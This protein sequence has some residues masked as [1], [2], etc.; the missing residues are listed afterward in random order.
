VISHRVRMKGFDIGRLQPANEVQAG[1][2]K[3]YFLREPEEGKEMVELPVFRL[4]EKVYDRDQTS[5]IGK[6]VVDKL[7]T[8]EAFDMIKH[9]LNNGEAVVVQVPLMPGEE[10]YEYPEYDRWDEDRAK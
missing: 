1:L 8:Y 3:T 9:K 6:I 7:V 10:T 4:L 5:I 2:L